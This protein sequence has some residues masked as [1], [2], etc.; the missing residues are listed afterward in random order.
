MELS[1]VVFTRR[2]NFEKTDSEDVPDTLYGGWMESDE[3]FRRRILTK[4]AEAQGGD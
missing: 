2:R 4:L 3:A 1:P